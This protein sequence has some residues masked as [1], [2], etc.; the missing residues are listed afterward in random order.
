MFYNSIT[1]FVFLVESLLFKAQEAIRH[2][3]MARI[4]HSIIICRQLLAARVV[5][6]RSKKMRKE[7]HRLIDS[8]NG[9]PLIDY[10]VC[11]QG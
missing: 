7:L 1:K 5:G 4:T 11:G 6:S 3:H 8:L 10:L 2:F 9:F